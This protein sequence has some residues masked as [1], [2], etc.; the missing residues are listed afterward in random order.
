VIA[1]FSN[2]SAVTSVDAA[3]AVVVIAQDI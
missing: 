3:S 2:F 1:A